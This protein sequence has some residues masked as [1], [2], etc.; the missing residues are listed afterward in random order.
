MVHTMSRDA[1]TITP[2][3][4]TTGAARMTVDPAMSGIHNRGVVII[5]T[6]CVFL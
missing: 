2:P 6:T 3:H 1:K 5:A 4:E